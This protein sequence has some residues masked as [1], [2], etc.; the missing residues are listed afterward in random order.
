MLGCLHR[1]SVT[2]EGGRNT[3]RTWSEDGKR[4]CNMHGLKRLVCSEF[5]LNLPQYEHMTGG[6]RNTLF[7]TA[8]K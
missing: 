4:R 7:A 8:G 2:Q 1:N 5:L 3:G 6:S